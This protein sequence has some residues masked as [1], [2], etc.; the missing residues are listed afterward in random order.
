MTDRVIGKLQLDTISIGSVEQRNK[1][2]LIVRKIRYKLNLKNSLVSVEK[3]RYHMRKKVISRMYLVNEKSVV[4]VY[5]RK[6]QNSGNATRSHPYK[7][8]QM[9]NRR[10]ILI[11]IV[12]VLIL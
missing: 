5:W 2:D 10:R 9:R 8:F 4:V 11:V 1:K 6:Y 7:Y 3:M 12:S